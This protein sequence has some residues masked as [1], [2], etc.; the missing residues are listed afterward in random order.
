MLY[1]YGHRIGHRIS[2][3]VTGD[4]LIVF[5]RKRLKDSLISLGLAA[6]YDNISN[7]GI[8]FFAKNPQKF[9]VHAYL[10]CVFRF[11]NVLLR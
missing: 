7:A 6:G 4:A 10:D 9:F 3:K 11:F 8:L 1:K 2:H 5:I